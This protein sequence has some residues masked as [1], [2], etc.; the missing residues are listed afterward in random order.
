M[1]GGTGTAGAW[2]GS[3]RLA[4]KYRSCEQQHSAWVELQQQDASGRLPACRGTM[5]MVDSIATM[6]GTP[7]ATVPRRP[8]PPFVGGALVRRRR[9]QSRLQHT[10]GAGR[11]LLSRKRKP[12]AERQVSRTQVSTVVRAEPQYV[13]AAPALSTPAVAPPPQQQ[14]APEHD[15]SDAASFRT[16]PSGLGYY[17]NDK[18]LGGQS[19]RHHDMLAMGWRNSPPFDGPNW[20]S[21]GGKYGVSPDVRNAIMDYYKSEKKDTTANLSASSLVRGARLACRL[22]SA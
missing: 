2:P 5:P 6:D 13:H 10:A 11:R 9:P 3:R 21:R 20:K 16:G 17:R 14:S 18:S 15:F 1:I 19:P 7:G 12:F 8:A 4:S 22:S